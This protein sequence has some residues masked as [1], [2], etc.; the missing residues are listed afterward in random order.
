ML[1][2]RIKEGKLENVVH[3]YRDFIFSLKPAAE[4]FLKLMCGEDDLSFTLKTEQGKPNIMHVRV[5]IVL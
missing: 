3:N 4:I 1:P 2:E 5:V